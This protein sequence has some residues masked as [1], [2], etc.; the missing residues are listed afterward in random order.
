VSTP[1]PSKLGELRARTDRQLLLVIMRELERA[2]PMA[3]TAASKESPLYARAEKAYLKV[4]P[5][6]SKVE[7]VTD[8]QKSALERKLTEIQAALAKAAAKTK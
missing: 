5:L 7:A 3:T 2:L 1:T 4:K 8:E 6:V